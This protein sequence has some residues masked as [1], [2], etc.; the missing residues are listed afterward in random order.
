[1][2]LPAVLRFGVNDVVTII[3]IR[4][5]SDVIARSLRTNLDRSC[6]IAVTIAIKILVVHRRRKVFIDHAVT[7]V[8]DTIT[9]ISGAGMVGRV[10]IIAIVIGARVP[11]IS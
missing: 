5:I 8:V 11:R 10:R 3:T 1:M 9:G 4:R 7:I 6:G 2:P